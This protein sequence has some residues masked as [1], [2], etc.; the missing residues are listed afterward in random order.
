MLGHA[1]AS[2]TLDVYAG[3]FGDDLDAVATRLDEAVARVMRTICGLA[4]PTAASLTS[5][6]GEA[7]AGHLGFWDEPPD[8][9]EPSTYALRDQFE[10]LTYLVISPPVCGNASRHLSLSAVE[11]RSLE[12]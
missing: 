1:S 3:L 11:V 6:N 12:D 4:P 5:G 10:G 9:I 7:Q 8:G 2:M